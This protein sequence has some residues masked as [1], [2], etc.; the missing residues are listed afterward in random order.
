L[1]AIVDNPA[2]ADQLFD[3]E[4]KFHESRAVGTKRAFLVE[5]ASNR[6]TLDSFRASMSSTG[7]N[8]LDNLHKKKIKLP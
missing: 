3:K 4:K 1:C 7:S 6:N 5:M 8:M 2:H